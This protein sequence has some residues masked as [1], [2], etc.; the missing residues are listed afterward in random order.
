MPF[1]L[2]GTIIFC[3]LSY[4]QDLHAQIFVDGKNLSEIDTK[5]LEVIISRRTMSQ[6]VQIMIDYGQFIDYHKEFDQAI[7]DERDNPIVF[8]SIVNTLNMMDKLGWDFIQTYS[9]ST[10]NFERFHYLFKKKEKVSKDKS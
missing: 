5:Y 8:K 1:K 7:T 3:I 6:D 4:T 10:N 2:I 9:A